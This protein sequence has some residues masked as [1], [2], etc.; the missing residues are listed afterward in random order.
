MK[1]EDFI[2]Q[3]EKLHGISWEK[4]QKKIYDT[5]KKAFESVST[6]DSPRSI[7]HNPQSRAMYGLDI[8]LKWNDTEKKDIGVSFIE[9][10]FMPDCERAC[11]YYPDFADTVF[12]TLFCGD[13]NSGEKVTYL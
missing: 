7:I 6:L 1:C 2:T 3:I 11:D 10:N 12:E 8:M 13:L 9:A 5:I 4:V